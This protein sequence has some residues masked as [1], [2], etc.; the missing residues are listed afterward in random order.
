MGRIQRQKVRVNRKKLFESALKVL[1]QFAG[2]KSVLEVEYFEEVGTG[3][4]PTLEFYTSTSKEFRKR[5]LGLWRD[6]STPE[7]E[8]FVHSPHG[9][10]PKPL[11][12]LTL[13]TDKGRKLLYL[14][15]TLGM[16]VAKALLDFRTVDLPLSPAFFRWIL[17]QE[18]SFTIRDLSV[19]ESRFLF[20]SLSLLSNQNS[21]HPPRMLTQFWLNLWLR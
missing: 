17:G 1:E 2:S 12:L 3:L 15:K 10:F 19:R 16:F 21:F 4:G 7:G 11:T 20:P 9:L 6:A 14:F 13:A 18:S 8:E 5:A